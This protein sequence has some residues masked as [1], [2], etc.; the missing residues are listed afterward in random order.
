MRVA[1]LNNLRAGRSERQVSRILTLLRDH[2]E[3][4]HVETGDTGALTEAF[5]ELAKPDLHG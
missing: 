5:A 4:L 1:I 3:V 2:P